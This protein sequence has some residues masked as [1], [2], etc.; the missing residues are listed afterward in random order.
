MT[1]EKKKQRENADTKKNRKRRKNMQN[2]KMNQISWEHIKKI[3]IILLG[4]FIYTA[5]VV[6]FALPAGLIVGGTTG[7]ALCFQHYFGIPIDAFAA[8]FNVIMFILGAFVLG[9]AFAMTTILSSI[10]YPVFLNVLQKA[11][12]ATGTPTA[13]PM[14]CTVFAGGLIGFGIAI[15]IQEG[16]STGGMDIPPLVLNKMTGVPVA[17][18]MYTCDIVLL[19]AQAVF[20]DSEEVMYG[21]LVVCIT[22]VLLNKVLV[23]GKSK[24]QLLIFSPKYREINQMI[25][26]R[27]DR[28]TTLMKIEGGYTGKETSAVMT[29]ISQ[30]ELFP[31]NEEVKKV[32][33][34]AFVVIDQV[35]EVRGIGFTLGK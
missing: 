32:D 9:K 15:V 5:G 18:V 14:L 30:R 19:L 28:G 16:A 12:S 10:A 35:K 11:A 4:N 21:I 29:V 34:K 8:V 3:A 27:F 33:P 31:I 22:S 2:V 1:A 24:V 13:D 23:M 6:Y 26:G 25:L 20:T 7:I 17:A